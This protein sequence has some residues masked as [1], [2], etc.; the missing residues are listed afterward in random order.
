MDRL[1][2]FKF[3]EVLAVVLETFIVYQFIFGLFEKTADKKKN[4]LCFSLFGM[5]LSALS[6]YAHM[7]LLLITYTLFG[8][9]LLESIVCAST[10]ATRIFS[11]LYFA[12]VMIVSEILCSALITGLG[13]LE[14]TNTF[15]YG[16]PRVLSILIAKLIQIFAVRLTIL[17]AQW[18]KDDVDNIDVRFVFPIL[19]CQA[20]SILLTYHVFALCFY[21]LGEFD[22]F[23]FFSISGIMYINIIIFWYFDRI[24]VA[25]KY[26]A[27]NQ[28]MEIK[29]K[30]QEDY[31]R[32]LEAHQKETVSLWHDIKKHIDL[33][34]AL[35]NTKQ[36]STAIAYLD[37]LQND[38]SR[39]LRIIQTEDP[40]IGALLTEQLKRADKEGITFNLD[41]HLGTQ[42]KLQPIDL[43]IILGNLFD[44]AFEACADLDSNCEK[45]IR[46]EI[47][48]REQSLF[49]QMVNS[50]NS[51]ANKVRRSGR[52]GFGLNNVKR[53]VGKYGGQFETNMSKSEYSAT[54]VIP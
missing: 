12:I 45:L 42:M 47:K 29:L 52:H 32:T 8:L 51:E 44:N 22:F 10:T 24:K 35:Y 9:F 19:L 25:Y 40:I 36:N 33:I 18:K 28:T 2:F 26:K 6:I 13:K 38:L 16:L 39:R 46:I 14:I 15:D 50:Y 41:I 30:L 48:Q 7:P 4:F 23:S 1:F 53:S 37:E 27:K 3:F 43:C 31:Y 17:I 49:I 34:K 5:G 11:V 20:C 21:S 54:I